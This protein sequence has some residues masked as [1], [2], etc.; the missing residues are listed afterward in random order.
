MAGLKVV[1][2]PPKAAVEYA[3]PPTL[4]DHT[5]Y[6]IVLFWCTV[7]AMAGNHGRTV[8]EIHQF[9]GPKS[10]FRP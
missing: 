9:S 2:S 10:F 5:K 8:P 1:T 7:G 3:D 4:Q 6:C